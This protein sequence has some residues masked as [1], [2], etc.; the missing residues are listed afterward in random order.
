M[1]DIALAAVGRGE[2]PEGL[3]E[4]RL[5]GGGVRELA[6]RLVEERGSPAA[7]RAWPSM[8]RIGTAP[9]ASDTARRRGSIASRARP[10]SSSAWP[11]SS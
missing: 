1:A 6:D 8:A 11:F 10:L 3:G 9:G 5:A 7:T 2:V 4:F